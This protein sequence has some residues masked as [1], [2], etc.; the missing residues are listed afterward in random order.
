VVTP[1]RAPFAAAVLLVVPPLVL[2]AAV[3]VVLASP[4]GAGSA[5]Q[6][7]LPSV[8]VAATAPMVSGVLLHAVARGFDQILVAVAAI[9]TAIGMSFQIALAT[10]SGAIDPFYAAVAIR[11]GYFV[12][13]G[14][15][16]LVA[17][18]VL[19]RRIDGL[20]RYPWTIL[21]A[22][23]L[24]TAVTVA[25]GEDVNGARLWL[26][27]GP[28]R[29]QPSEL[30]RLLVAA[31]VAVYLFDRRHLIVGFWRV[32][33]VD[34]PPIPYLVPLILAVAGAMGILVLQ[35]DLGMAALIA[36]GAVVV[37]LG[38]GG[39]R[40]M[41]LATLLIVG[42]GAAGSYLAV[43]R[44]R[45]RV[46]GWIDPW[47]DPAGRGF[48]LLQADFALASG[49]M[50]GR[51]VWQ[52]A[53]NVPEVHTDLVLAGIGAL[54]GHLVAVAV[55]G[56]AGILVARCVLA[57][58]RAVDGFRALLAL[59]IALMLAIQ[60]VLIVGGTLRLLPLTGLTL[61]LVSYG[62]TSMIVSLFAIGVVVGIGASG[63]RRQSFVGPIGAPENAG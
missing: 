51:A 43:G 2:L 27:A 5:S 11:H 62:G 34:L 63:A 60:T 3:A 19:A 55:I 6:N 36:L 25:A 31:F 10:E 52:T 18:A 13:A 61:P 23:L 44:V 37:V 29:F 35:N 45:D 42:A 56:L 54:F 22:A 33:S 24:L 30:G 49:G 1:N 16:A 15:L 39:S 12:G 20:R 47:Q 59:T 26:S 4:W 14:F 50:I 41:I 21:G 38:F 46:M 9:M 8:A 32:G 40:S 57:A 7:L 17:G 58:L 53:G 28:V 48:Q